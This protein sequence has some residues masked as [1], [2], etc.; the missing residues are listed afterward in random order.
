MWIKMILLCII[1]FSSGLL[2]AFAVTSFIVKLGI[3]PRFARRTSSEDKVILY[4]WMIIA[5]VFLGNLVS[6]FKI[7]IMTGNTGLAIYGAFTGIYVGCV[8]IALEEVLN[9]IPII[10]RRIKLYHGISWTV[11]A[12]AIGKSLGA[13]LGFYL[14]G[15]NF[16]L[17]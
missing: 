7:S 17:R 5:G 9:S 16:P 14:N 4:E 2:I 8:I 13:M 11:L 10:S 6:L 3:V 12:I 1:G 15:S